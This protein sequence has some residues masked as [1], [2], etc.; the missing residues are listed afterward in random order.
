MKKPKKF[1]TPKKFRTEYF[2]HWFGRAR[3]FFKTYEFN[4]QNAVNNESESK[5]YFALAAFHLHQAAE[6]AYK[7]TLLVF[8]LYNPNEHFLEILGAECEQYFPELR[9][10]FTKETE[11]Q[12]ERFKLLEYAY[13]GGRYD[14]KYRISKSDLEILASD[15]KSLLEITKRVCEQKIS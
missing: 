5:L 4:F 11:E 2:E 10:L 13:I 1:K 7:T 12:K 14:P 3:G 9:N 6:S 8:T 15:V